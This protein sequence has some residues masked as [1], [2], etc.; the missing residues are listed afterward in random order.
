MLLNHNYPSLRSYLSMLA[1][2]KVFASQVP[3]LRIN[4][5]LRCG[6]LGLECSARFLVWSEAIGRSGLDA[7]LRWLEFRNQN[8]FVQP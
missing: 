1:F 4:L 3:I 7:F 2:Q 8:L 6:W 5:G